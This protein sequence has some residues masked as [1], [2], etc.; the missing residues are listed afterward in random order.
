MNEL[1]ELTIKAHGGLKRW[2]QFETVSA[3][4]VQGGALWALIGQAGTLDD[5][6]VTVGSKRMGSHAPLEHQAQGPGS[7]RQDRA[8]EPYGEVLRNAGA[9]RDLRRSYT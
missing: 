3:H 8:R 7:T 9:S 4:L 5:T 6:N 1:A 2:G